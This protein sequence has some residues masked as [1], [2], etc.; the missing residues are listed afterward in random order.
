[1]AAFRAA[2]PVSL[3]FRTPQHLIFLP[4]LI[5]PPLI[6]LSCAA[7]S[8]LRFPAGRIAVVVGTLA[9]SAGFAAHSDF[10]RLIGPFEDD[11]RAKAIATNQSDSPLYRIL[12]QPASGSFY[13]HP[14]VFDFFFE[15]GDDPSIRFSSIPAVAVGFKWTA[16]E[17]S[18]TLEQALDEIVP[19]PDRGREKAL[20]FKL[21]SIG[22]LE[23]RNGVQPAGGIGVG[24]YDFKR[25]VRM[26]NADPALHRL[27]ESDQTAVWA[28]SQ[29]VPRVYI[30]DC[31]VSVDQRADIY[32]LLPWARTTSSCRQPAFVATR[33]SDEVIVRASAARPQSAVETRANRW[34]VYYFGNERSRPA[35]VGNT[36]YEKRGAA[37]QLK[38]TRAGMYDVYLRLMT[39]AGKQPVAVSLDGTN[40]ACKDPRHPEAATEDV[41]FLRRSYLSAGVHVV[42]LRPCSDKTNGLVLAALSIDAV[43][44]APVESTDGSATINS[45]DAKPSAFEVSVDG[46]RPTLIVLNDAFDDRWIGR[47]KGVVLPHL[48]VNGYGNA[49]RVD[50]PQR[51]PITLEFLP[52]RIA[53]AGLIVSALSLLGLTLFAFVPLAL[54]RRGR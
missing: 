47:Q 31:I 25:I 6:A 40:V 26:D 48:L 28:I 10:L 5:A 33:R 49:W 35:V 36:A 17:G 30:P 32:D 43:P 4:A 44:A 1:M 41:L 51:G 7:L 16:N 54:K 18:E 22:F 19:L 52:Q 53:T 37:F 15:A 24:R 12:F 45:I 20:L 3:L 21:A 34:D 23:A 29:P 50:D 13:F 38:I 9:V 39:G 2:L 14:G 11:E 46:H 27:F 42:R 8:V